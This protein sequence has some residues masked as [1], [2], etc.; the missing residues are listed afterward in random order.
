MKTTLSAIADTQKKI[1][2]NGVF[3]PAYVVGAAFFVAIMAYAQQF[4]RHLGLGFSESQA[5]WGAFGDFIGGLLNPLCA[6]MAFIW[7]VRSYALQKTE[8]A[9]TRLTLKD[10]LDT[11]TRQVELTLLSTQTQALSIRLSA[12]GSTLSSLRSKHAR[13]V[14]HANV[15]GL[16]H[17]LVTDDGRYTEVHLE[18]RKLHETILIAEKAENAIVSEL[19]KLMPFADEE[20]R[21]ALSEALK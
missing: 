8:L 3:L 16:G 10:T 19:N 17:S 6:Y 7:L 5:V 15:H 11:Q 21:A 1:L 18:I 9:E 14:S 4:H 12:L 2:R 20:T 13:A